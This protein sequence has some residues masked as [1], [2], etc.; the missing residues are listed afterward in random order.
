MSIRAGLGVLATLAAATVA[1]VAPAHAD[2]TVTVRGTAFPDAGAQLGFVGC[3]SLFDRA[4]EQVQPRIG[5]APGLSP[6]GQRSLGF[7][8]AGGNAMGGLFS[9]ASVSRAT[10]A[11][12]TV[13]APSGGTG[14][15]YAGYR[16]PAD[17]GTDLVWFGRATVT[18][19][20]GVWQNVD[21]TLLSYVWTKYDLA[22]G[23][24]VTPASTAPATTV[25]AFA[26]ANGGDGPGLFTVGFGCD[27]R[28][29]SMDALRA[30]TRGAV[31]TYDVEG[32]ATSTQM[33]GGRTTVEA[34]ESVELR[35]V[36]E[37]S[38]GV[39][40]D[41][42]LLLEELP[43]GAQRWTTVAVVDADDARVTV[44]PT[45]RTSY[46]WRFVDRP[47][48]EASE[49]LT[50]VVDVAPTAPA[51]APSPAAPSAEPAPAPAPPKPSPQPA[52]KPPKA[53][54]SQAPAP[55]P[56]P[57]PPAPSATPVTPTAPVT[58]PPTDG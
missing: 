35:G 24:V 51:P 21:A 2:S 4:P 33:L 40:P 32:L 25:R 14:V 15:A 10:A 46:R 18:A 41:A 28:P 19:A 31:T 12:M 42:T 58:A 13:H 50:Y 30:G 23:L 26:A 3:G 43:A 17:A 39:V 47:L 38:G 6:A 48:A 11:G 8:L 37:V 27:G 44:T 36:L 5:R 16:S 34:G 57:T 45:T 56:V 52:P 54:P 22:T 7:D 20:T 49:S 53:S 55:A 9:V 1:S 29:F